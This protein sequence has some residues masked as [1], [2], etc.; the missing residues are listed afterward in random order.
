MPQGRHFLSQNDSHSQVSFHKC[1]LPS[2]GRCLMVLFFSTTQIDK[3]CMR[4]NIRRTASL[5][6]EMEVFGNYCW[7]LKY[8]QFVPKLICRFLKGSRRC[9]RRVGWFPDSEKWNLNLLDIKDGWGETCSIKL[10]SLQKVEYLCLICGER[11]LMTYTTHTHHDGRTR[12]KLRSSS[13]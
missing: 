12:W 7:K 10:W 8:I 2:N 13:V 11:Q 9:A 5:E 4:P 6:W 1:C 3:Y